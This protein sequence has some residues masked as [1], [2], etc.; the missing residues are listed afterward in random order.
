MKE[1]CSLKHNSVLRS[2]HTGIEHFSW[3]VIWEELNSKVPTLIK[4]LKKLLPHSNNMSL[5]CVVCLILKQRCKHI[6]LLQQVISVLLYGHGTCQQVYVSF[7][8]LLYM[9][10]SFSVL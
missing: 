3:E 8:S 6:S 1:I 5:S 10:N 2:N 4:F 7:L 9:V